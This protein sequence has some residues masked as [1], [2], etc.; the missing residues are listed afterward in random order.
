MARG[1]GGLMRERDGRVFDRG[2]WEESQ[3]VALALLVRL[4][5]TRGS[6]EV[7]RSVSRLGLNVKGRR[8][9]S[10]SCSQL[11][12]CYSS[13]K[14][15]RRHR[16]VYLDASTALCS[17]LRSSQPLPLPSLLLIISRLFPRQ[18]RI[19]STS[20][21]TATLSSTPRTSPATHRTHPRTLPSPSL[22]SSRCC[23]TSSS[24]SFAPPRIR[25]HASA[26]SA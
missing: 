26:R 22:P 3:S 18:Q 7:L 1:K 5:D 16:G 23:S 25:Q 2:R 11:S 17:T 21:T 19:R 20:T 14:T 8:S 13:V 4:S 24:I 10:P 15:S 9:D 12:Q 6:G